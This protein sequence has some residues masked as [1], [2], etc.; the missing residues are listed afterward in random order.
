M[1]KK[2]CIVDQCFSQVVD[3]LVYCEWH[4]KRVTWAEGRAL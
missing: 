4:F 3:D 2:I 1:K